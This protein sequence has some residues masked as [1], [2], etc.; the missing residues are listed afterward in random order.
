MAHEFEE[1]EEVPIRLKPTYVVIMIISSV[2]LELFSTV[3]GTAA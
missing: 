3:F 1:W 2:A